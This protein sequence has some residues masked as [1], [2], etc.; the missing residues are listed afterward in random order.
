MK[1]LSPVPAVAPTVIRRRSSRSY[2]KLDRHL[3]DVLVLHDAV[4]H[5]PPAIW[6]EVVKSNWPNAS[7]KAVSDAR[8]LNGTFRIAC[9]TTGASNVNVAWDVPV[10]AATV[11]WVEASLA[12]NDSIPKRHTAAVDDSHDTVAHADAAVTT[13]TVLV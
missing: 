13:V 3:T 6:I 2:T 7:P 5:K 1:T 10:V 4:R 12:V 11:T 8:L 9:D